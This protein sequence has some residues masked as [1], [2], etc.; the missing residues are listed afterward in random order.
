MNF[1][2][3]LTDRA[4]RELEETALWWTEH[5]SALQADRWYT[6][7][8]GAIS[9]LEVN[10]LRCPIAR[11]NGKVPY[12]LRQLAFGLGRRL[13]H[14]AVWTIRGNAVVILSVRHLAR[15]DFSAAE[16]D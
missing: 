13:T 1:K 14:R 15:E 7:F 16:L 5:Y 10:P 3:L 12:E 9:S 6:A 11:E 2:V 4:A 8:L